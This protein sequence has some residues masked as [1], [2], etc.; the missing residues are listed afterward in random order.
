MNRISNRAEGKR[1]TNN[2]ERSNN[3]LNEIEEIVPT[4]DATKQSSCKI[5]EFFFWSSHLLFTLTDRTIIGEVNRSRILFQF[6]YQNL[7]RV[8]QHCSSG[9]TGDGPNAEHSITYFKN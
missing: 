2:N 7:I 3:E 8:R 5:L 9:C 4:T 6:W 1:N